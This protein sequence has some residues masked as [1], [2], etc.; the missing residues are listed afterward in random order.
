MVW[1]VFEMFMRE[2]CNACQVETKEPLRFDDPASKGAFRPS[3]CVSSPWSSLSPCSVPHPQCFGFF[4]LRT[5]SSKACMQNQE[6]STFRSVAGPSHFFIQHQQITN[7][8]LFSTASRPL[9]TS[10]VLNQ[11]NA[12]IVYNGKGLSVA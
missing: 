11:L 10:P 12:R 9:G 2:L 6:G 7:S 3:L 4:F 1:I 8:H 5:C